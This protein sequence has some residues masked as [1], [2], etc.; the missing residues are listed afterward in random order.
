[1]S[2]KKS[3]MTFKKCTAVSFPWE[4]K[5]MPFRIKDKH[6][7][8][9]TEIWSTLLFLFPLSPQTWTHLVSITFLHIF[10]YILLSPIHHNKDWLYLSSKWNMYINLISFSFFVTLTESLEK[11]LIVETLSLSYFFLF[12]CFFTKHVISSS[13]HLDINVLWMCVY[14][15]LNSSYILPSLMSRVW[16]MIQRGDYYCCVAWLGLAWNRMTKKTC[17]W[18]K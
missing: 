1:M 4:K 18:N 16:L 6:T 12:E 7:S 9:P 15:S 17:R 5:K 11:I 8:A 2:F 14:V 13:Y 10:I 3:C